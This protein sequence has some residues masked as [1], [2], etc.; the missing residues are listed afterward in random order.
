MSR[1][2]SQ[3]GARHLFGANIRDSSSEP[4]PD[5]TRPTR[6]DK[7]PQLPRLSTLFVTRTIAAMTKPNF[8]EVNLPHGTYFLPDPLLHRPESTDRHTV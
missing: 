8:S 7:L 5:H 4:H 2:T 6:T 3:S 1:K